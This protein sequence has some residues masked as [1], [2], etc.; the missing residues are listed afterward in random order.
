[1]L[2]LCMISRLW[3][4]PLAV[5]LPGLLF[6]L[7]LVRT[8]PAWAQTALDTYVAAADPFSTVE[9]G[10]TYSLA[11]TVPGNGYDAY[12]LDMTSQRWRTVSDVNR[13]DWQHWLTV[14]K[15]D[16]VTQDTAF[17]YVTGG[18]NGGGA[19]SGV[20]STLAQYATTTGSVVAELRMVP[21]QPLFF[22]DE[23]PANSRYE[24]EIIAYTFDKYLNTPSDDTWPLL[25]PMVKSAVRAMDTVQD[26]VP[27]VADGNAVRQFVVSGASKRGWTTWLTAAYDG[28]L[29]SEDR[30]VRAIIPYVIDVLGFEEQMRHHR[31]AYENVT[32]DMFGDYSNAIHDYVEL[33]VIDRLY[34]PAGESLTDIVDPRSYTDRLAVPKYIIN[35]TGDEFFLPDGAQFYFDDLP[36][37]KYL[38]YVPNTNHGVHNGSDAEASSLAF[39]EA[40][41][42]DGGASLPEFSWSVEDDGAIHV[43]TV[44]TPNSVRL[45]Q[46]TNPSTRDFQ[47]R[48]IGSAWTSSPLSDQG[49]GLYI[50]Q[51]ADP[52]GSGWS[53]FFVELTYDD[54]G[55]NPLKFT[56]EVSVLPVRRYWTDAG[57]GQMNDQDNW[58]KDLPLFARDTAVFDLGGDY[59]VQVT[60]DETMRRLVVGDDDVTLSFNGST[61]SATSKA[62]T[63]PSLVVGDQAGDNGR[64]ELV[65]GTVTVLHTAIGRAAGTAGWLSVAAGATLSGT[66]DIGVAGTPAAAGGSGTLHILAQGAVNTAGRVRVWEEGTVDLEEGSLQAAGI[67][68]EGGSLSGTGSL[69]ADVVNDGQISPGHSTGTL[70]VDGDYEQRTDGALLVD[71]LGLVVDDD[72]D[73]LQV[74]GHAAL[75]GTLVVRMP[76]PFSADLGAFFTVVEADAVGGRFDSVDASQAALGQTTAG[77]QLDWLP[78]YE[79]AGAVELLVGIRGDSDLDGDIDFDDI[80]DLVMGLTD[81]L[82]YLAAKGHGSSATSDMD[83]DGDLDFDDIDEFVAQLE[84]GITGGRLPHGVPEPSAWWLA[85]AAALAWAALR[86]GAG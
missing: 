26:Y 2:S 8:E 41:L 14:I 81:P 69:L 43:E 63:D 54:G 37:T 40:I 29:A 58:A 72:Y 51:V 24:D 62:S 83:R 50:G 35:S 27:M 79:H 21:N 86:R 16:V 4:P 47:K 65:D 85:V 75:G 32:Q 20:D 6:V 61:V 44:T 76:G 42:K 39:Y 19:P 12:V 45:W 53:A 11:N 56:T 59:S 73:L 3:V 84:G 38:R 49:N 13:T 68:L 36:G 23:V 52:G 31:R 46:A 28:L 55:A 1:M 22:T 74:S 33:N 80:D 82:A 15:P 25:S 67:D 17:L 60:E 9:L 48:H 57:S 5:G 18:S 10:T 30:R 7:L 78:D 71:V 64:L 70:H 77:L 66:G 34:T